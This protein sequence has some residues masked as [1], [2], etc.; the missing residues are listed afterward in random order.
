MNE[1]AHV[2]VRIR[3]ISKHRFQLAETGARYRNHFDFIRTKKSIGQGG[4]DGYSMF[5]QISFI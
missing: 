2:R 1:D 4:V 3:S 5:I